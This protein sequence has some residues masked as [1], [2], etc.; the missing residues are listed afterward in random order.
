MYGSIQRE[1][2]LLHLS[3]ED[4]LACEF[5]DSQ[6]TALRTARQGFSTLKDNFTVAT[7][8]TVESLIVRC[9]SCFLLVKR[10]PLL[11][12]RNSERSVSILS[13]GCERIVF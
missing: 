13:V 7:L 2:L 9:G 3:H 5:P 6:S 11:S 10:F 12:I 8:R 4:G 1:L